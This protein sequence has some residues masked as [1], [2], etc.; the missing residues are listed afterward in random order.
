MVYEP[1]GTIV[2]WPN[3]SVASLVSGT[4]WPPT[5]NHPSRPPIDLTMASCSCGLR[6]RAAGGIG[7]LLAPP[8]GGV[9]MS[10]GLVCW[11]PPPSQ[12]GVQGP[13]G[14]SSPP[15]VGTDAV[16]APADT[17]ADDAQARHPI[18]GRARPDRPG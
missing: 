9:V 17:A 5:M 2:E 4:A 8:T 18:A 12:G 14:I 15:R 6:L 13:M 11:P 16:A 3:V 7:V 10:S 1:V